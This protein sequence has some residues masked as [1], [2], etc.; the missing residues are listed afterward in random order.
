MHQ[1]KYKKPELKEVCAW[2]EKHIGGPEDGPETH[3]ICVDCADEVFYH[4]DG[5][6]QMRKGKKGKV[7]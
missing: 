2:C 6:V 4:D 7:K 5:L 1:R 3:G